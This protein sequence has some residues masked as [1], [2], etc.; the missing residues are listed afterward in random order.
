MR[1]FMII[2]IGPVQEFIASAR[3]SRDLWFGS[4]FL[5]E[6]AK[7][8]ARRLVSL[9][10]DQTERLIFPAITSI[11]ALSPGSTHNVANKIVAIVTEDPQ[12][13][14]HEIR[15]AVL[16]RLKEIA[17]DGFSQVK[18]KFNDEV[19]RQ[20]LN[21]LVEINWAAVPY[22]S[23]TTFSG[24]RM[25]AEA[26]LAARK[27]TRDF[28]PVT[29]GGTQPKSSLDGFRESVIPESAFETW[30]EKPAT[31]RRKYGVRRGE[32]LCGV[33]LLKRHGRG[34]AGAERFP[35]TSHI[36]SL[37]FVRGL[38]AE[39]GS[40]FQQY[41]TTLESLGAND[42]LSK[43]PGQQHAILGGYDGHLLFEE[44][45]SDFFDEP[46]KLEMAKKALH[47]FLDVTRKGRPDPYYAVLLADGDSMGKLIESQSDESAHRALSHQLSL[48]AG[49][50]REIVSDNEGSAF[51]AGGD[52]VLAI[53]P[54]HT[55]L[56]CARALAD[57]FSDL[58]SEFQKPNGLKPSLSLGLVVAHQLDPL[59]ETLELARKTEKIAK[60][61]EGKNAIAITVNKRSGSE[62]TISGNRFECNRR[63]SRFITY[64][65]NESIPSGFAY[66]L[67]NL[68]IR[69]GAD[70]NSSG[71]ESPNT[72]L[73]DVAPDEAIRILKRKR[74]DAGR[75]ELPPHVLEDLQ[76]ALK[77]GL[78]TYIALSN[79]PIIA[80]TFA[81]AEKAAGMPITH[82][83]E[84]ACLQQA[85]L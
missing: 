53:A 4:W 21:D 82:V 60:S 9:H 17:D 59:S 65:R 49:R 50:A 45:L 83:E 30:G 75:A 25:K 57:V 48:F 66:E 8:A 23:Q 5:S 56:T 36:A 41:A 2:S 69:L 70:Q 64:L 46:E 28:A 42:L 80:Q 34:P 51:Y 6:L 71:E 61:V 35:S 38:P 39:A 77:A 16:S 73:D 55:A 72:Y 11:E 44:R 29:W 74:A 18:D 52:D 22:D 14:G 78:N 10:G 33:G 12:H 37:P 85:G 3:R 62:R 43:I 79:E 27:N 47:L 76:Q 13:I 7:S 19:A 31:L 40:L 58:L 84:D 54:V 15:Q 24:V 68:A 20:Q 67:R 81:A 1:H 63:L 32:R 26:L